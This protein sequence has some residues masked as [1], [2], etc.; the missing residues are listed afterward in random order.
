MPTRSREILAH[1]ALQ[2]FLDQDWPNKEIVIVDDLDDRSFAI[3]PDFE[4]VHYHLME[5]RLTIGAKRNIAVKNAAGSIIVHWDSD[6]SYS[7]DRISHQVNLLMSQG[8]EMV[9]YNTMEFRDYETMESR[10]Y[11]GSMRPIGVSLCYLKQAWEAKPFPDMQI[12]EDVAFCGGHMWHCVPADGRII[13]RVHDGN[14]SDKRKP[15]AETTN[16]WKKI[17]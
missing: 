5:R 16:Q 1:Q 9:G 11:T 17:P 10:M 4:G 2:M 6:D 3:A 8:V 12:Q 15:W 13:A 14:T 7:E